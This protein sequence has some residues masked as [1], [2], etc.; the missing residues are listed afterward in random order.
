MVVFVLLIVVVLREPVV[1][2]LVLV[3][4][5]VLLNMATMTCFQVTSQ[6][7]HHLTRFTLKDYRQT[8]SKFKHARPK[9]A[10]P[11]GLSAGKH[12]GDHV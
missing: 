3:F 7:G 9:I 4:A 11:P 10:L 8:S 6:T 5:V 2:V 1:V 12:A